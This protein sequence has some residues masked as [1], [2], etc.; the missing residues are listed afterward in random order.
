MEVWASV[1]LLL[2]PFLILT[3]PMM[4]QTEIKKMFLM[5]IFIAGIILV[6][7]LE[8]GNRFPFVLYR[9]LKKGQRYW[10]NMLVMI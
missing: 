2:P 9:W 10:V 7:R 3:Q 5:N 4:I 8:A 1:F 6:L